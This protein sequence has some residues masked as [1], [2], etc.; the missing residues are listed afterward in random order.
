MV[1]RVVHVGL[2]AVAVGSA[3]LQ[4]R[5]TRSLD[6]PAARSDADVQELPVGSHSTGLPAP[7]E[8]HGGYRIWSP[9][10]LDPPSGAS[11]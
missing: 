10:A 7:G 6:H 8:P 4:A 1:A 11:P 2:P 3:A 9:I 5:S